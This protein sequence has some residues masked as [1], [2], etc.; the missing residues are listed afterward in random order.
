MG[1]EEVGAAWS[2]KGYSLVPGVGFPLSRGQ[3]LKVFNQKDYNFL[4]FDPPKVKNVLK[5]R[6]LGPHDINKIQRNPKGIY[7]TLG[8]FVGR[9]R[10]EEE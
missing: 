1:G 4:H 3:G 2:R 8:V 9:R 6:S 10:A 7:W 5:S